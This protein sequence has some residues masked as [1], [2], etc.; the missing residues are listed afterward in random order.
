MMDPAINPEDITPQVIA[1]MAMGTFVFFSGLVIDIKLL[2][3]FRRKHIDWKMMKERLIAGP[4]QWEDGSILFLSL[5]GIILGMSILTK[6]LPE[7]IAESEIFIFCQLL[8]LHL[9]GLSILF[10][11]ARSK[12]IRMSSAWGITRK[13]ILRDLK[14]GAVCYFALMPPLS[15]ISYIYL[16]ILE[17]TSVEISLQPQLEYLTNPIYPWWIHVTLVIMAVLVAP[18]VE[19]MIFRGL[20]LPVIMRNARTW[21]SVG[22]VSVL[23]AS[24]HGH[25]P[26]LVPIFVL[27][28]ALS[29]GYILSGSLLVPVVTHAIFNSVSVIAYILTRNSPLFQ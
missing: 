28:V 22:L 11:I 17:S 26:A 6:W 20:L 21:L 9:T 18:A 12:G 14:N 24:V 29:M 7:G 23:F 2:L 8:I 3:Q 27:A 1:V 16:R 13:N 10:T 19:E 4:W 25:L 15:F 5:L